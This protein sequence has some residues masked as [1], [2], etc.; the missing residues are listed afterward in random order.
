MTL[1]GINYISQIFAV[2][3]VI[4]SLIFVG[5]QIRLNT[6][7]LKATSHHAVTDGFNA[8]NTLTISDPKVGR[9]FQLGLAGRRSLAR[10]STYLS[11]S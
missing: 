8:I 11:A 6:R 9:L 5:Y 1:E 3:G 10:M 4:A 2:V 7:A